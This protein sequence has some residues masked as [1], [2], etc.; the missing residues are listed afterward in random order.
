LIWN[1]YLTFSMTSREPNEHDK[2]VIGWWSFHG[3]YRE[4]SNATVCDISWR[5]HCIS[6]ETK[7]R[8]EKKRKEK[9]GCQIQECESKENH[10]KR[11]WLW[12]IPS[13]GL[14]K[15]RRE[16]DFPETP[17]HNLGPREFTNCC[18]SMFMMHLLHEHD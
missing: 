8:T 7:K 15:N 14:E 17:W 16:H 18:I 4:A 10:N 12:Y 13:T 2:H 6:K 11:D 5:I 9:K 1:G 3:I